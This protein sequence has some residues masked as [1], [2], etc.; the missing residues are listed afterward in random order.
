VLPLAAPLIVAMGFGHMLSW[1]RAALGP[2]M[3]KLWWAALAALGVG[4]VAGFGWT[5]IAGLGFAGATWL[6]L[7]SAAELV[8]RIRLFRIPLGHSVSRLAGIPRATWGGALAH[9][10]LGVTVAGLAGMTLAQDRI[11]LVKPGETIPLAGYEWTLASLTDEPGPNYASRVA[12]IEISRHGKPYVTLRPARHVFSTQKNTTTD[13]AIHTNGI[14][15]FYTVLGEERDGAAVL[16]LHYNFMAPWIW[17]GALIMAAGGM[18]SLLD[19][20]L[21]VGAPARRALPAGTQAA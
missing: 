6:I 7:S 12:T 1:K 14:A 5:A 21:R 15:D 17:F 18:L 9:A 20:R 13:T 11:V 4:L 19:R 16:R 10:G 8:E 3:L 2:A